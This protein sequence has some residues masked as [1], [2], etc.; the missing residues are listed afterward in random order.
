MFV[1]SKS[2]LQYNGVSQTRALS[3]ILRLTALPSVVA[4]TQ[5]VNSY[6]SYD[7]DAERNEVQTINIIGGN[8]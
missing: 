7:E 2:C 3:T 8:G 5:I 4:I 1:L 6:M